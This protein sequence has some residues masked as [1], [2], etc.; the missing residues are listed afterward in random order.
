[1]KGG[2]RK[3]CFLTGK[4]GGFGALI[5][6]FE[7]VHKDPGLELVVI[8]TD[9]HLSQKFGKTIREVD[10]W[11]NNVIRVPMNQEDDQPASRSA[12]L[13]RA[14][15]GITAALKEAA[16]DIFVVLG[17]R[18]EVYAAVGA[19]LH[20]G[21]P[22]AHI[23]GGD[24]SGNVDDMMR[25]AITKMSHI[26]FAATKSSA[27]RI[28]RMG[29]EPWRVHVV[30]DTHVDMLAK[31]RYTNGPE[32][33][34]KYGLG[35]EEKFGLILL[36]PET[37]RPERSY[38]YMKAV[39][40]GTKSRHMRWIVVY[41]C[42]DH[43]YQGILDAINEVAD[44]PSFLIHKNIPAP[45]FWGLEAQAA[46]FVGNSSAGLI[47]APYFRL[48]FVNIGLRQIGRERGKNVIDVPKPTATSIKKA[49][50]GSLSNELKLRLKKIRTLPFG[51]G[52]SGDMIVDCLKKV[53]LG[54]KLFEKR[55]MY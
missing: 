34:K 55:I 14:M 15:I 39:L 37:Y 1:M 53:R 30:G 48:P 18:G 7:L 49:L 41:P 45:D 23:Q 25:H 32:V 26:H 43:G 12:A 5:P 51:D 52:Q 10:Q 2:P 3:I 35:S 40:D 42:S 50:N 21:I 22:V 17:D 36:H 11:V 9:M 24:V 19:A 28:I 13:G 44:D 6:T 16:P 33:R 38:A 8:A 4:R 47:E 46:V 29:E 27:R 54:T 31:G 20:L